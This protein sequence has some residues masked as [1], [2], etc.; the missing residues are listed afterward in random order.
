M[1]RPRSNALY[2]GDPRTPNFLQPNYSI[3]VPGSGPYLRDP[4]NRAFVDFYGTRDHPGEGWKLHISAKPHNAEQLASVVLP[5]L[6]RNNIWH[7]FIDRPY[8]LGNLAG[9]Q[10]GKF[11]VVYTIST[12]DTR[13]IINLLNPLLQGFEG[14]RVHGDS[15]VGG[16]PV[17]YARYGGFVSKF[18]MSPAG[19][20]VIDNR[21]KTAPF[22]APGFLAGRNYKYP[23]YTNRD[24]RYLSDHS[25]QYR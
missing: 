18:V 12:S 16:S 10:V 21:N 11:L 19:G 5:V 2:S 13:A 14:P 15:P 22:W 7:K 9:T 25:Y 23:V 8:V 4:M 3:S 24:V 17:L 20:K 6:T 1:T